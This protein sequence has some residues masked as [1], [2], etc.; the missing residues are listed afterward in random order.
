MST[1]LAQRIIS[2]NG[3]DISVG[4]TGDIGYMC[5]TDR[6]LYPEDDSRSVRRDMGFETHMISNMTRG[7]LTRLKIVIDEVLKNSK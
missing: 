3:Q 7:D 2:V 4:L 6:N 1:K 5:I